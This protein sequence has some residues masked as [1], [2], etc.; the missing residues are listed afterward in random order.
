MLRVGEAYLHFHYEGEDLSIDYGRVVGGHDNI[1][2][3][4]TIEES[5][6]VKFL[7]SLKTHV[8]SF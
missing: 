1:F 4:R 3:T 8:V 5:K 2:D 7:D 6:I